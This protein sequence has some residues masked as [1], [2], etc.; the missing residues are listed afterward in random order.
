M[1]L[2]LEDAF[3][4]FQLTNRNGWFHITLFQA[5]LCIL[6][7]GENS[8]N[9]CKGKQY[10]RNRELNTLISGLMEIMS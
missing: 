10:F 2:L 7:G 9:T 4:L 5:D 8:T 3:M 1:K 6:N